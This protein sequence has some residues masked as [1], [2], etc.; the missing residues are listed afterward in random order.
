M[1]TMN[2][3]LTPELVKLVQ[4]KVASGLY[5]NASEVIRDALR[6]FDSVGEVIFELKKEK[7]RQAL[8]PG[9]AQYDRGEHSEYP[10]AQ[11]LTDI[12]PKT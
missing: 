4:A 10:L 6:Q 1:K 2:V 11:L 7:L 12:A 3:S 5:N 9:L 8:Q